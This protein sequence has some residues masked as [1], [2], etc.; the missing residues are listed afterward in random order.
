[1]KKLLLAG[2]LAGTVFLLGASDSQAIERGNFAHQLTHQ[3]APGSY[4]LHVRRAWQAQM[5]AEY[6]CKDAQAGPNNNPFN[7][8]QLWLGSST[9]NWV[10]VQ[11]YQS[12]R[13]G[14]LATAKTLSY[15]NHGYGLIIHRVLINAPAS[16]I[17]KAI[18][19]SDW[20]TFGGLALAVLD[21]IQHN[22]SPNTL[23]QLESC[24]IA[25]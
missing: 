20:G 8:T 3:V 15:P 14:V 4:T 19:Q 21:D 23:G 9:Y 17:I 25:G 18:G 7:T 10:G 12:G 5:Q 22:R 2:L 24:H 6:S 13:D 16:S 11:R 1:M